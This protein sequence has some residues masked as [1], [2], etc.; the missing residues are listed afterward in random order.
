M[1]VDELERTRRLESM[2]VSMEASGSM[3]VVCGCMSRFTDSYLPAVMQDHGR[4]DGAS[5]KRVKFA[6][7]ARP[8]GKVL[9]PSPA[10]YAQRSAPNVRT[11]SESRVLF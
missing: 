3:F 1:F 7:C 11:E 2:L 4:R 9:R 8:T 6:G 10:A 5:I